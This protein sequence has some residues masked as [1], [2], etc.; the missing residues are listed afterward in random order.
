MIS[1]KPDCLLKPPF[2]IPSFQG[3]GVQYMNLTGD[4]IQ[5]TALSVKELPGQPDLP[6][7][8]V[9][10]CQPPSEAQELCE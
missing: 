4:K 8:V 7:R 10:P 1:S 5:S 6:L 3:L 9:A 2:Q